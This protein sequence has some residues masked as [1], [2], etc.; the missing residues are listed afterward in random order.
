MHLNAQIKVTTC[1]G[2]GYQLSK[3]QKGT[4]YI[5]YYCEGSRVRS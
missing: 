5:A 4:M 2:Y 1:V 3:D